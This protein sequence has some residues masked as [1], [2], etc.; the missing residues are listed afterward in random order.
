[1][2]STALRERLIDRLLSGELET[3]PEFGAWFA[4]NVFGDQ[5]PDSELPSCSTQ[6]GHYREQG[7]TDILVNIAWPSGVSCGP[8]E[9]GKAS[10][11]TRPP[12]P[13]Y[14]GANASRELMNIRPDIPI[15]VCTGFSNTISE[16]KA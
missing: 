13:G 6:I 15:I 16:E 5:T 8:C 1:M 3:S 7:E 4:Q 9:P 14:P 2:S 12:N 10:T 11:H